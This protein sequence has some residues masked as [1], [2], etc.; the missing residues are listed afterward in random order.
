MFRSWR[1]RRSSACSSSPIGPWLLTHQFYDVGRFWASSAAY[2]ENLTC[3]AQPFQLERA[4][5]LNVETT[6]AEQIPRRARHIDLV[7]GRKRDDPCGGVHSNPVRDPD[8]R[9]T[10]PV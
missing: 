4:G 5:T 2:A 7:R 9:T 1:R 3:A 10:S 8:T 6:A